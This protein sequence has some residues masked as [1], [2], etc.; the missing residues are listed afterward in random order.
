MC[1]KNYWCRGLCVGDSIVTEN[2]WD[3]LHEFKKSLRWKSQHGREYFDR[4]G[5]GLFVY[6]AFSDCIIIVQEILTRISSIPDEKT[7]IS[8]L[9]SRVPKAGIVGLGITGGMTALIAAMFS[10][11]SVCVIDLLNGTLN[12]SSPSKKHVGPEHVCATVHENKRWKHR[13]Q[14]FNKHATP[15]TM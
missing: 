8:C 7:R 9:E 1:L 12:V 14:I 4:N 6:A 2:S 3:S 10:S 15:N 11:R 13:P 5:F